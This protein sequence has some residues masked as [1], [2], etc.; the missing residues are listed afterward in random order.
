VEEA[1]GYE[2]GDGEAAI[3]GCYT[4]YVWILVKEKHER[5]EVEPEK[6]NGERKK[7]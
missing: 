4:G 2:V 6:R 7:K 3:E 1:I 5:L